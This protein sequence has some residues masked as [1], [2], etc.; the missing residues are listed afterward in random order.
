MV[1]TGLGWHRHEPI[2]AP[3]VQHYHRAGCL[4]SRCARAIQELLH[5]SV[6]DRPPAVFT[7]RSEIH[8]PARRRPAHSRTADAQR[9]SRHRA[10]KPVCARLGARVVRE[11]A[12]SRVPI[13]R[14]LRLHG[15]HLHVGQVNDARECGRLVAGLE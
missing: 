10:D 12:G 7:K 2:Q 8:M 4:P 3:P 15:V 13:I 1:S 11:N 14:C 5:R 6:T 9:P